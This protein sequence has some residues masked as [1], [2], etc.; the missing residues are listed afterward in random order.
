LF[1]VALGATAG[2]LLGRRITD[3]ANKWTPEGIATQAGDGRDKVASWWADVQHFAAQRE[4]EL[5]DALGLNEVDPIE[6]FDERG[7]R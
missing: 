1:Y 6:Q 2:V 7:E 4:A 3:V 5:R